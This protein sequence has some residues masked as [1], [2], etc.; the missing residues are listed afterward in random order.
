M[1]GLSVIQ[2]WATLL[3][4]GAKAFETRD[5]RS[6]VSPL[7]RG[8]I[9]IHAS[10]RY[11]RHLQELEDEEPFRSALKDVPRPL[12][13]GCII[14]LGAITACEPTS[15]FAR[16]RDRALAETFAVQPIYISDEEY[17]FGDFYPE[18]RRAHHV[19]L[20]MPLRDPISCRGA[21]GLWRIPDDVMA[22]LHHQLVDMKHDE[23]VRAEALGVL[24]A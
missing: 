3:A 16:E 5:D 15:R 11:P 14:A 2:P 24:N 21:L 20:V 7:Y 22:Q 13:T 4:I 17:A 19:E 12:P 8:Q 23:A 18:G 10:K 6:P 9:A 1:R